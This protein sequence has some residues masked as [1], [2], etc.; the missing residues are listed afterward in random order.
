MKKN[1]FRK[2]LALFLT[3]T[4][5]AG[6]GC[7]DYDD[8]ID[9]LKGQIND[10]KGQVELKADASALKAV[11][12]K[13]NGID[14]S[15]FVTNSGLQTELDKR[16]ADYAKKSDLKDW[17]TSD[18]VLK[19]IKAQGYQTKADVQKLIEEATKNQ[20]TA[21]DVKKI[22]ETM[23]ASDETMGK[24]QAEMQKI[25]QQALV[26]GKYVTEQQMKDF[27]EGK[28]YIT[29]AD[30]LSATQI[31]QILT[32]VANSV[33]SET[34][35]VT[36]AIKKVLGDNF[37][38]YMA[39]YMNDE[40]VK[41][42]MGKTITDTIL[43]ELTDANVTLKEA[44]EAMIEEGVNSKLFN[45]DGSAIYLKEADLKDRFDN[46][47]TQ[48]RNLWSAIADLA[49]RI[50]SL[51]Y[52]P[53]SLEEVSNNVISIEGLPYIAMVDGE[54]EDYKFY[55]G[56]DEGGNEAAI[57]ATFMV[58][59]AALAVKMTKEN[60]SFVTEEIKTRS[61]ASFEVV[62]VIDQ[63]VVTGKFTVVA[64][65]QYEYG[66]GK[67]LAI[68]L[69]VKLA[70]TGVAGATP[71]DAISG[72]DL[73]SDFTS[74][75]IGTQYNAGGAINADLV[76]GRMKEDGNLELV[77]DNDTQFPEF[78]GD[79]GLKYN[80]EE[81]VV[82]FFHDVKI[83]YMKD[84]K[85]Q[86]LAAI[87]GED[88]PVLKTVVPEDDAVATVDPEDN[89]DSYTLTA[90]T[91]AIKKGKGVP[92]LIDDVITSEPFSFDLVSGEYTCRVVKNAKSQF[93]IIKDNTDVIVSEPQTVTWNY[94][95][96]SAGDDY[97]AVDYL[98]NPDPTKPQI[99][100]VIYNALKDGSFEDI[101]IFDGETEMTDELPFDVAD[102]ILTSSPADD[103]AEQHL[104]LV[105]AGN[106][107]MTSG[108]YTVKARYNYENTDITIT[109][110]VVIEGMPEITMAPETVTVDYL[111]GTSEYTVIETYAEKLWNKDWA[112][113]YFADKQTFVDAIYAATFEATADEAE[114]GTELV[115]ATDDAKNIAI[116]LGT[117]AKEKSYELTAKLTADWGLDVTVAVTVNFE[118]FA[119][120]LVQG[121]NYAN[122]VRLNA[123]LTTTAYVPDGLNLDNTWVAPKDS[124]GNEIGKVVFSVDAE[125]YE[126]ASVDADAKTLTWGTEYKGLNMAL[127][128]KLMLDSYV[129]DEQEL[130]VEIPD[131]I[132]D[133]TISLRKNAATTISASADDASLTVGD[134]LQLANINGNNVF[135]AA[136]ADENTVL[137]VVV[138]YEVMNPEVLVDRIDTG[139]DFATTGTITVK[140][141][142]DSEF[143]G[144]KT[145][146]VKVTVSYDYGTDR[147]HNLD[148]K[149][150][151]KA[152]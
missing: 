99:G 38:S 13:L 142:A 58:S 77:V 60:V 75:F 148:I 132:K 61:A 51:V 53:T 62:D 67:T 8:D 116:K 151:Q 74:A 76:A 28:G 104:E 131:P 33:S 35:T 103:R 83:Y 4:M 6:V 80:D 23:I 40:T 52:V 19:L 25:I 14:F 98:L 143:V 42:E 47:D 120:E 92:A 121:D 85:P 71:E 130:N 115:Q 128:V 108:S 30:Q 112:P 139:A 18:E 16:L 127:S 12:D 114:D 44:I 9:D 81:T 107:A 105:V 147:V 117:G 149:V 136:A 15:S 24:L 94:A 113:K 123:K 111:A 135:E 87:W 11:T 102:I 36:D 95:T 56:S 106:S 55:L 46:Y 66:N 22:F 57:E 27:V 124:K 137:R 70:G 10:L 65:T 54:G 1:L 144:E 118:G 100:H 97:E 141:N 17:L 78:E 50:Q 134:L 84:G 21:D 37:A 138:K 63:D 32:A 48:L 89:K 88:V 86:E 69:N 34:A 110:P 140:G 91:A 31:N 29:G 43:K 109:L 126:G 59:P 64:K 2:F 101:Q 152:N 72:E 96:V 5:L 119:G 68:A 73:G 49:G 146:K 82:E 150:K 7:K 125:E 129:L 79:G 45:P 39:E 122:P 41:A 133:K 26:D 20:L 93:T 3:G 90:T 145:V